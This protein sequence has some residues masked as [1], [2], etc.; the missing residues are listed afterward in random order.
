[1]FNTTDDIASIYEICKDAISKAISKV[2]DANFKRTLLAVHYKVKFNPRL[3]KCMAKAIQGFQGK[4]HRIE[5]N[6]WA[7]QNDSNREDTITHELAHAIDFDFRGYTKHD[8]IWKNIHKLLGGTGNR[9]GYVDLKG[10][11]G[12]TICLVNIELN[13]NYYYSPANFNR[14]LPR[15][16]RTLT[17]YPGKYKVLDIAKNQVITFS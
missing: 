2:Y 4:P 3:K 14:L 16:R 7:Y 9:T 1:M 8:E 17:I 5:I 6:P 13:K 12:L 15:L 10:T 11:P